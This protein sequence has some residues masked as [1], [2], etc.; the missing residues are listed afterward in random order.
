[1]M[2]VPLIIEE[3]IKNMKYDNLHSRAVHID[4]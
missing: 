4:L 1:M 3:L 2:F